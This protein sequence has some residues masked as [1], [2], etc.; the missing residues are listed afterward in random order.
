MFTPIVLSLFYFQLIC[1]E[2][3]S[4]NLGPVTLNSGL[5]ARFYS[6]NIDSLTTQTQRKDFLVSKTYQT[7]GQYLGETKGVTTVDTEWVKWYAPTI[8]GFHIDPSVDQFVIELRGYYKPDFTGPFMLTSMGY[9]S[10]GCTEKVEPTILSISVQLS[11]AVYLNK[12]DNDQICYENTT[13]EYRNAVIYNEIKAYSTGVI[14]VRGGSAHPILT[15]NTYYPI[16]INILSSGSA[17]KTIFWPTDGSNY[18]Y[19]SSL[20]LLSSDSQ[21]YDA[22]DDNINAEFPGNCPKFTSSGPT[23]KRDL[24]FN[25]YEPRLVRGNDCPAS[26]SSSMIS[27]SSSSSSEIPSSSSSEIVSSSTP[28]ISSSSSSEIVSSS[29]SDISS[30]SSSEISSSSYS[31]IVSSS[32][33]EISI[34]NASEIP[35]SSST[36]VIDPSSS[37]IISSTKSQDFVSSSSELVSSQFISS[38]SSNDT[39]LSAVNSISTSTL[40]SVSFDSSKYINSSTTETNVQSSISSEG[41]LSSSKTVSLTPTRISPSSAM[42]SSY[43]TWDTILSSR[44]SAYTSSTSTNGLTEDNMV[45]ETCTVCKYPKITSKPLESTTVLYETT[46]NGTPTT[47]CATVTKCSTITSDDDVDDLLQFPSV[48]ETSAFIQVRSGTPVI[49]TASMITSFEGHA[50]TIKFKHILFIAMMLL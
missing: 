20:N 19:F 43:S 16:R 50:T 45:T 23:V 37:E 1:C 33:S 6:V 29:T 46:I 22:F 13:A 49:S 25:E 28:D 36:S 10:E 35:L 44:N 14:G 31:E 32:T 38:S 34:S 18:H 40:N 5:K 8:Y 4:S 2:I 24:T 48:L 12:T 21:D 3:L 39:S 27:S 9:G 26:S 17:L 11:S 7:Q 15:K 41:L 30:S 42:T 47:V